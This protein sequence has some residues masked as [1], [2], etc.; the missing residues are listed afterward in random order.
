MPYADRAEYL[1]YQ[2]GYYR[3]RKSVDPE[4]V[5][6]YTNRVMRRWTHANPDKV[7][8]RNRK[9]LLRRYGLTLEAYN[10]LLADQDFRCAI[11]RTQ[12]PGKM[13]WQIDHC[14]SSGRVRGLLCIRC[15]TGLGHFRDS[16]EL[17][18]AAKE[19]LSW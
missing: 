16:P 19:Y 12:E 4:G 13:S 17:L 2:K 14:H 1:E 5:R 7:W 10:A 18:Q 8:L 3:K 11:C 9:S 15:N 6:Q